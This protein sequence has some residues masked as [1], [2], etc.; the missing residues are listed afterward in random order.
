LTAEFQSQP[1]HRFIGAFAPMIGVN[2]DAV[3]GR[4]TNRVT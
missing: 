1:R 3:A 4:V 2:A